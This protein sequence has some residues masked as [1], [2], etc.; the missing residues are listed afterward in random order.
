MNRYF[1][2][3]LGL[4]VLL[5]ACLAAIIFLNVSN[6]RVENGINLALTAVATCATVGGAAFGVLGNSKRET[7]IAEQHV[8]YPPPASPH[9]PYTPTAEMDQDSSLAAYILNMKTR[10][11]NLGINE[12]SFVT[13]TTVAETEPD[14]AIRPELLPELE[15]LS[16]RANTEYVNAEPGKIDLLKIPDHFDQTVLLGEP[17]S[18]KTTLLQWLALN[19]LERAETGIKNAGSGPSGGKNLD[20]RLP[21]YASL[22]DWQPGVKPLDFLSSQVRK[23]VGPE[24]Y[25]FNHFE[26]LLNSGLF[27]LLLDGLNELPGRKASSGEGRHEQAPEQADK[28]QISRIATA[29]IDQRELDLRDLASSTGAQSKFVLSCRSHEYFD[30]RRWQIVRVLPMTPKQ[31]DQFINAYLEPAFADNLR[32]SL[33]ENDNLSVIAKNPFVLRSIIRIYRPGMK[34]TNRGQIFNS[35]YRILLENERERARDAFPGESSLTATIGRISFRMLEAGKIGNQV[36]LGELDQSTRACAWALAGTGLITERDGEFFFQHQIIQE[37]FA[38]KALDARAV[39]HSHKTLLADKRWSEVVALWCDIDDRMPKRVRSALRARNLPW[40]RPKTYPG[41]FL[42]LYQALTSFAVIAVAATYF[43]TWVLWPVRSLNIPL[44]TLGLAP[45]V[46]LAIALAIRVIWTILARHKRIIINSVYVLSTIRDMQALGDIISALSPLYQHERSEVARYVGR[47]FGVKA[48]RQ[49][50]RGLEASKWRVRAGCV[51]ILGEIVRSKPQDPD[52]IAL[53]LA[54][55]KANDP[56]LT[57]ALV[58]ALRGCEDKRVPQAMGELLSGSTSNVFGMQYRWMPLAQWNTHSGGA[59][60]E[61]AISHFEDLTRMEHPPLIRAVALQVMGVLRIP[62]CEERLVAIAGDYGEQR[63]IR[64]AAIKGLG[65][66]QTTVAVDRLVDLGEH[67]SHDSRQWANAAIQQVTDPA[68]TAALVRAARSSQWPIRQAVAVPLGLSGTTEAL[69][70]LTGLSHDD[71]A[72]VREAT[73]RGLS[74]ID[75][76]AAVPVLGQLA[77]DREP[78]VRKTALEALRSRYP[79]LAGPVLISLGEEVDYPDRVRAIRSIGSYLQPE[80][81]DRL[82]NLTGDLD[83]GVRRAAQAAL[84]RI[85]AKTRPL[86]RVRAPSRK[87]LFASVWQNLSARLQIDGYREMIREERLAGTPNSQ[88]WTKV[89]A[90]IYADAELSRQYQPLLRLFM[91]TFNTIIVLGIFFLV[92]LLGFSLWATI[93]VLRIWPYIIGLLVLAGI[94]LLP[95]VKRAREVRIVGAFV[96]L[97]RFFAGAV[98]TVV[99]LGTITYVWWILALAVAIVGLITFLVERRRRRRRR[100]DVRAALQATED[101]VAQAA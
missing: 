84:R 12:R 14:H 32:A 55:V 57:A 28:L 51:Q 58:E 45:I 42:A 94:S 96:A 49:V 30:S 97:L 48:L 44:K 64:Q 17:G 16:R 56:Q 93:W 60:G 8:G 39:R 87:S 76:P 74:R 70:L 18:G 67:G 35:L 5:A 72:L 23:L 59:W 13:L 27:V 37:F 73:A 90:R 81:E 43:W 4:I 24:N 68:T 69:D 52:P 82:R 38:A 101:T 63:I 40:R 3:A 47:S 29:S 22:S 6:T 71:N 92:L 75:V 2:V 80:L 99:V 89:N 77:R 86:K 79:H 98:I 62:G 31:I 50:K 78:H 66:A 54:V 95:G 11:K 41:P 20:I 36:A 15:W 1:W 65:L 9:I 33:R 21:L 100:L 34:L 46:L 85:N 7:A 61:D 10:L 53:L 25:Y 91:A 26:T 19:E 83:K 88:A